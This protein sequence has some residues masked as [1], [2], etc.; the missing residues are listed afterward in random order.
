MSQMAARQSTSANFEA[1]ER[2]QEKRGYLQPGAS[3]RDEP[4]HR[5]H[6]ARGG[7]VR[8][9]DVACQRSRITA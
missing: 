2:E 1:I 9:L 6:G 8:G 5:R 3:P 7:H 4:G